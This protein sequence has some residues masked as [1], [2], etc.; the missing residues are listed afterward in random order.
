VLV[1]GA[2]CPSK[3]ALSARYLP[4]LARMVESCQ[5][6]QQ[7]LAQAMAAAVARYRAAVQRT[8]EVMA[9]TRQ[10]I[11]DS[12]MAA[13]QERQRSQDWIDHNR[14]SY[15]RGEQDYVSELE[16]GKIYTANSDGMLDR[17]TGD[18][19]VGPENTYTNTTGQNPRH[20]T[21]AAQARHSEIM[22]PI[23]DRQAYERAY[24]I[25]Q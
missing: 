23:T 25:G 16:G 6:N 3:P 2:W 12:M 21:A 8:N 5:V 24:G 1:Q 10:Q 7:W 17:E 11:H 22:N 14:T 19:F 15:I 13:W 4:V 18:L 20:L 9:R